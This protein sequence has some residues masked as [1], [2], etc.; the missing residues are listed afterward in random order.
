MFVWFPCLDRMEEPH[1]LLAEAGI[2]AARTHTYCERLQEA[3][4]STLS[5]LTLIDTSELAATLAGGKVVTQAHRNH[6]SAISTAANRRAAGKRLNTRFNR[7]DR[8]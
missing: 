8:S 4:S 1:G 2:P 3:E 5:M 6:A 7:G